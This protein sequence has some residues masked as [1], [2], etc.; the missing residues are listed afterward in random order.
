MLIIAD[1]L[2]M[3]NL[4]VGFGKHNSDVIYYLKWHDGPVPICSN[5]YELLSTL[6]KEPPSNT[7][8]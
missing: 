8:V 7:V 3:D 4:T 1:L 6:L 2:G 5:I